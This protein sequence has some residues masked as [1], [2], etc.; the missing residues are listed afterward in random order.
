MRTRFRKS[1]RSVV[2]TGAGQGLG[3]KIALG[4]AAKR[5]IVFGTAATAQ[6][7]IDLRDASKG[8]VSLAV[9]DLRN[10]GTVNAWADGVCEAIGESGL[11]ILINT[12]TH[13]A[14]A[15]L[16]L[17]TLDEVRLGFEVNVF[18][19]L[20]VINAFLPALRM[21]HGRIVQISSWTA[22]TPRHFDGVSAASHA[23][24]EAFSAA[25]RAELKPFGIDVI[26]ASMIASSSMLSTVECAF[27]GPVGKSFTAVRFFH[28]ATVFWLML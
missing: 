14:P 25:Y 26:V 3:R 1:G 27:L 8:R 15:P 9:C 5:Y 21:A 12:T 28:L 11:E 18:G 17:V 22:D 7:A 20:A 4:L 13:L 16:E 2:V 19:G 10:A 6:E 24:M 23:A